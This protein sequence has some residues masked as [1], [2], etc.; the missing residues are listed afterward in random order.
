MAV[1]LFRLHSLG[2]VVIPTQL[3]ATVLV[4]EPAT[5]IAEYR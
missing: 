3:T 2:A 4:V 5:R 1:P